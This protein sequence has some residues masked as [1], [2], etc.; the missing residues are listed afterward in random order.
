MERIKHNRQSRPTGPRVER[1]KSGEFQVL[2]I[3]DYSPTF[4]T[5]A[6]AEAW[7]S[8]KLKTGEKAKRPQPRSCLCCGKGFESEGF[9]NR[10][11]QPCRL[12]ASQEQ[13]VPFSFGVVSGRKRA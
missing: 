6:K 1:I 3:E 10:L 12:R 9:H 4:L 2:G 7:L 8:A 13:D 5:R 11:C